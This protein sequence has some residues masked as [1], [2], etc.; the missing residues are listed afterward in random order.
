MVGR[1]VMQHPWLF[2]H[3]D[4]QFYKSAGPGLSRRE[5][6]NRYIDYVEKLEV[7]HG[8]SFI[9]LLNWFLSP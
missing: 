8:M 1:M 4:D 6:I 5:V 3:A 2:R 7:S 9:G